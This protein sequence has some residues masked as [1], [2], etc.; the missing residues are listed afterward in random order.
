MSEKIF[1]TLPGRI[2]DMVACGDYLVVATIYS[3][4]THIYRIDING[5]TEKI[6]DTEKE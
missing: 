5:R 6:V 1:A 3:G 2:V 4:Q